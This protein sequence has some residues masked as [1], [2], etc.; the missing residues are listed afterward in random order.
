MAMSSPLFVA[1]TLGLKGPSKIA[2]TWAYVWSL[3]AVSCV[4]FWRGYQKYLSCQ[5]MESG[6]FSPVLLG[7]FSHTLWSLAG[8]W[9][10][11]M[12]IPPIWYVYARRNVR[13]K[14]AG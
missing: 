14:S 8:F 9:V 6:A 13:L 12:A 3:G 1:L 4:L 2:A 7:K 10:I 5:K 11:L